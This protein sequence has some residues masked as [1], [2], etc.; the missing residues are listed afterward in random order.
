MGVNATNTVEAFTA[1]GNA[2]NSYLV[3]HLD[4]SDC[5]TYFHHFT[6]K[7]TGLTAM[8]RWDML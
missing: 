4:I 8:P 6:T 7:S 5:R 1:L 3:P 2:G